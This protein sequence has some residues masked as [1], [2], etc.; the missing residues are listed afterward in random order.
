V[1]I[2]LVPRS[3]ADRELGRIEATA[4]AVASIA[5]R[6]A[7]ESYG[8]VGLSL[9]IHR[10]LAQAFRWQRPPR[11]VERGIEVTIRGREIT[12]D[13]FVVV[14]YGTRL[15]EV[16]ANAARSVQFAVEHALGSAVVQVNV[17]IQGIRIS[18]AE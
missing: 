18:R 14:E 9:R 6:A 13:L 12:I 5:R 4:R 11:R 17:Y 2:E 3:D 1:S 7:M 16:A 15:S 8:V 10:V